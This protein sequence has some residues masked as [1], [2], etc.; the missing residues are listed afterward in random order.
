MGLS[1]FLD[2]F[3]GGVIPVLI[4]RTAVSIA[5]VRDILISLLQKMGLKLIT[6]QPELAQSAR[7]FAYAEEEAAELDSGLSQL[8]MTTEEIGDMLHVSLF[9]ES[10]SSSSCSCSCSNGDCSCSCSDGDDVSECVVCLRKFHGGE[11]IRTL[12]C[13]HVF[14]KICVD[15][16][17]LDYENMTCPL[18]RVCLVFPVED[19]LRRSRELVMRF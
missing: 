12:P 11:E 6:E 19:E 4:I 18:C 14:H 8:A 2:G 3:E 17:I 10:S 5:M 9:Q 16:W 13:G 15:K 7:S 1:R